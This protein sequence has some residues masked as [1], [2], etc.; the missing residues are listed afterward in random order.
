MSNTYLIYRQTA[1]QLSD[2]ME[3]SHWLSQEGEFYKKAQ[4]KDRNTLLKNP[5]AWGS[6]FLL[7]SVYMEVGDRR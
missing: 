5:A 6:R 4:K 7:G 2:K 3:N 1:P